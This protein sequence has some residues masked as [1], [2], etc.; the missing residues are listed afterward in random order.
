MKA[1][2]EQEACPEGSTE[3]WATALGMDQHAQAVCSAFPLKV[4]LSWLVSEKELPELDVVSVTG[5]CS[6]VWLHGRDRIPP[7]TI[8]TLI[9]SCQNKTKNK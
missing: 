4:P 1:L 2:Q 5:S 6:T 9:K 8:L 7:H 3:A